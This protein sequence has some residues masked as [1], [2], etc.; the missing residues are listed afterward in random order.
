MIVALLRHF[1][2]QTNGTKK[3][4]PDQIEDYAL[5][6]DPRLS[7]GGIN[8]TI[9]HWGGIRKKERDRHLLKRRTDCGSKT[10]MC[11]AN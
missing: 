7:V 10:A 11:S 2:S 4:H 6:R 9:D 3:P 5:N 1:C 8:W